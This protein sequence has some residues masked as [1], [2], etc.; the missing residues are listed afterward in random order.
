M[1]THTKRQINNKMQADHL[2]VEKEAADRKTQL[3]FAQFDCEICTSCKISL[4]TFLLEI[5]SIKYTR[6]FTVT[7][8]SSSTNTHAYNVKNTLFFYYRNSTHYILLK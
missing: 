3:V 8:F 4:Y 6:I 1:R 5:I 7:I 2:M